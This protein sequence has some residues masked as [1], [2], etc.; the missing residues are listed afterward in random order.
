MADI[1]EVDLQVDGHQLLGWWHFIPG[2]AAPHF[3]PEKVIALYFRSSDER[4]RVAELTRPFKGPSVHMAFGVVFDPLPLGSFKA[5]LKYAGEKRDKAC[6]V[7]VSRTF[8]DREPIDVIALPTPGGN[9]PVDKPVAYQDLMAQMR[10]QFELQRLPQGAEAVTLMLFH[11]AGGVSE[12]LVEVFGVPGTGKAGSALQ[13]YQLSELWSRRNLA[14]VVRALILERGR[15][16]SKIQVVSGAVSGAMLW[17][18]ADG[19]Y[20][21]ETKEVRP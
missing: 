13:P 1:T 2:P 3:V 11:L 6:G 18:Q 14:R 16:A 20:I 7:H 21:G 9:S 17:F 15:L 12:Q 8:K 10:L 5:A 19:S 4:Y